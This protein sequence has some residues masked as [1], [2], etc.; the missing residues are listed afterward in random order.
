MMMFLFA[1]ILGAL[2]VAR[3]YGNHTLTRTALLTGNR[4]RVFAAKVAGALGIGLGFGLVATAGAVIAPFAIMTPLGIT[5]EWSAATTST[6]L[7]VFASNVL[8]AIWGGFLGWI[9]RN[10][11]G[12]IATVVCLTL[13]VDPGLQRLVPEFA[14]FLFTIALSSIYGDE[15]PV[16]LGVWAALA[17]VLGWLAVTGFAASRLFAARDID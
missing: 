13:L 3:E 15:K 9:I 12:A 4:N 7:G 8:A 16:L 10:P 2:T 6:V 11:I 14:Q 1:G 17:C 5:P